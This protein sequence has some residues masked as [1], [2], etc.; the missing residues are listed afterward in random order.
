MP[1]PRLKCVELPHCKT[2]RY[3]MEVEVSAR[4]GVCRFNPPII[5]PLKDTF[6]PEKRYPRTLESD[7]CAEHMP[8]LAED[9]YRRGY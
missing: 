3:Y 7:T 5:R 1:I 2:C 8:H 4:W 6:N 9:K